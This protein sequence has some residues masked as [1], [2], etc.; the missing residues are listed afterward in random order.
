MRAVFKFSLFL[1]GLARLLA[2]DSQA[3][4]AEVDYSADVK[5]IFERHCYGCHGALRQRGG[6]RLDAAS[7]IRKGGDSG[8]ALVPGK[9]DESLLWSLVTGSLGFRMPPEDEGEALSADQRDVLRRWIAAGAPAPDSEP[10]PVDPREHWSYQPPRRARLPEVADAAWSLN[11]IDRLVAAKHQEAGLQPAAEAHREVLLRRLYLNLTGL[12]P[13]VDERRQFL[14]DTAPD[15]YHRVVDR[16]LASPA[17]GERWARHWMDV[18][19]YSDWSG[20]RDQIR[21]SRYHIWRWRDW[22]VASLNADK[23]YDRMVLEMLA[24]DELAPTDPEVLAA[25]GYLARNWYKFNRHTWLESTVEHTAK[26]FLGITINCARCHDHKYDPISQ[27]DY[28]RMRAIFEPHNVRTDRVPNEPDTSK[29]G[30]ARVGDMDLQAVTYLYQRGDY[31]RPDEDQ[32]M[33]PQLPE[34]FGGRLPIEPIELP[35][36]AWYPAL[37]PFVI[38]EQLSAAEQKVSA[39]AAELESARAKRTNAESDTQGHADTASRDELDAA[40]KLAELKLSHARA[41]RESLQARI[42]AEKAKHGL[43]QG[44]VDALAMAASDAQRRAARD[45]AILQEATARWELAV[46]KRE[47]AEREGP[48]ESEVAKVDE[49]TDRHA[50][51]PAKTDEATKKLAADRAAAEKAVAAAEKKLADAAKKLSAAESALDKPSSSYQPL[52]ARYPQTSTGRRL[53]LAR[54]IVDRGNPLAARVAVNHIWMRH[55]GKPLVENVFDFGLRSEEPLHAELLDHLAVEFMQRGWSMKWLHRTIVTSR[56]YRISSLASRAPAANQKIDP[57]NHFIWRAGARR[58]EAEAVRDSVLQVAGMLDRRMG[59]P[60]IDHRQGQT[61]PRRSLYFRHAYEK[62]VQFLE[63]F[64]AASVNECYRRSTSIVPQQALALA[65]STLSQDAARRL[66]RRLTDEVGSPDDAAS[67]DRFIKRAFLTVL[68]RQ[69]TTAELQMCRQF[70]AEQTE[71]LADQDRLTPFAGKANG[72]IPP[73]ADPP[74]RARENLVHVLLNHNDMV[75][76]R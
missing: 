58:L 32:V 11:P 25:T 72:S 70:L 67:D 56:V 13:S 28:Y 1:C 31:K 15:A 2:A 62:Q 44:D 21:N 26:A 51:D 3:S 27:R 39:T 34:L 45:G 37:R 12:P 20:Y 30:L 49:A 69:A 60:D 6:L 4:A 23:G 66:A 50:S 43:I 38:A 18:W 9:V 47:L 59:G 54:W 5:P 42:A 55:F 73:A 64:D 16:L 24:G 75:T 63:L 65:N 53:A 8:P 41:E 19:R 22:I 14:A 52:G 7:L 46:A 40:A 71:L 76:V 61:N 33:A 48:G 68:S 29:D 57:D 10:I 17:Y 36:E 35:V 74:L